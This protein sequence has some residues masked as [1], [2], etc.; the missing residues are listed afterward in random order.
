MSI[1]GRKVLLPPSPSPTRIRLLLL[2]LQRVIE[3]PPLR[4]G[5]V[6]WLV[7]YRGRPEYTTGRD[8]VTRNMP[9][10]R[11]ATCPRTRRGIP[12]VCLHANISNQ[13]NEHGS[14]HTRRRRR[15][16]RQEADSVPFVVRS[17]ECAYGNLKYD[18]RL[19]THGRSSEAK[20]AQRTSKA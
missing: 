4:N 10:R 17:G 19:R 16:R 9:A 20:M 3:G 8:T 5:I 1:D 11:H 13:S 18:I 7:L 12:A 15:R 14:L 6:W 2:Q